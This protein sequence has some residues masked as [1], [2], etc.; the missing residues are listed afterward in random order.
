M[1]GHTFAKGK[2]KLKYP[3]VAEIKL[4]EIRLDVRV[5]AGQV[6]FLSYAE[7]PLHNLDGWAPVFEQFMGANGYSRLDCGVLINGSF[8]DTYSYVRSSK[9]LPDDLKRSTIEFLLFDMP[10][11]K[12]AFRARCWQ[13]DEVASDARARGIPM[14]RPQRV[15][16]YDEAGVEAAFLHAREQ[17]YEGIMVKDW[18]HVYELGKRTY[19]WLK[20]KPENDAD[21]VVVKVNQ[22]IAEDG[23]PHNRAGSL[24]VVMEDGSTCSVPGFDHDFARAIWA[25]PSLIVG[26]WIEFT[27]MERD[28]QGGYRHPRFH[29][30]REDK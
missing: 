10:E 11:W 7:K 1:K 21:G 18:E 29:R 12:E 9:G 6:R 3:A 26:K 22:A 28:R 30:I 27:Y 13:L 4:D 25:I 19:G 5:I 23:T 14:L 20:Y 16:V 8:D 15:H 17:G 24:D 2:H